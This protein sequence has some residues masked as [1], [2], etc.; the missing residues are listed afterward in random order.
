M[1]NRIT[2]LL[3]LALLSLNAV[4][5]QRYQASFEQSRWE[6][7]ATPLRCEL[8]HPIP[9]YG[10][11]QFV[12]SAGGELA[13]SIHVKLAPQRDGVANILSVPPFWK[14]GLVQKEL[15]QLTQSKG[16]MPF[17]IGQAQ[18]LRLLY[19][20]EAGMFPTLQYKDW[21][22]QTDE[23]SVALSSV[24][25]HQALPEFQQCISQLITYT[26]DEV[27]D[28]T[29]LF[30]VNKYKIGSRA[31]KMLEQIAV[32][33]KYDKSVQVEIEGYTDNEGTRRYNRQLADR[34]TRAVE[35]YLVSFG[36]DQEQIKRIAFGEKKPMA[37]NYF[38]KGRSQNRRVVVSLNKTRK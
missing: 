12:H 7:K 32:Y 19:E 27:R 24:N 1:S 2:L 31:K 17:Y 33:A 14:A 8:N 38:D 35:A 25:F 30:G 23:V 28:V 6:L 4:A 10:V 20:L 3:P 34:R 11:G 26:A 13:F 29:L 18:A 5:S 36:V 9:R 22:D 15:G 16:K 21:A 37:S